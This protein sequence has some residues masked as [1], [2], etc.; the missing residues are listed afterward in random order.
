MQKDRIDE[1]KQSY[2]SY[3]IK[4]VKVQLPIDIDKGWN[5][6]DHAL[7]LSIYLEGILFHSVKK[8]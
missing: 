4:S 2:K 3:N 8:N 1:K 6:P 7:D 5:L